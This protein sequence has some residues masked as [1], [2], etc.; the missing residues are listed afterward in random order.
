M[1]DLRQLTKNIKTIKPNDY[2]ALFK[3]KEVRLFRGLFN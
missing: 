3:K 1:G 2:Y